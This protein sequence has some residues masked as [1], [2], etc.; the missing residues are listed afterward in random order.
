MT[1]LLA[2][3]GVVVVLALLGAGPVTAQDPPDSLPPVPDSLQVEGLE[4]DSLLAEGEDSIPPVIRNLPDFGRTGVEGDPGVLRNWDLADLQQAPAITLQELLEPVAGMLPVRGGDYA[5]PEHITAVGLGGGRVRVF[6]DGVEELP[7]DGSVTDLSRV[8]LAG[9]G[10]VTL[11]REGGELRIELESERADEDARPLTRIEAGTGDLETNLFRGT[12][13]QPDALGG[14]VGVGIERIDTRG[15]R[16]VEQ[17]TLSGVWLRYLRPVGPVTL[18]AEVRRGIANIDVDEL[19]ATEASRNTWTIRARAGEPGGLRGEVYMAN[20]SLDLDGGQSLTGVPIRP[21]RLQ[22][23]QFGARGA[24]GRTTDALSLWARGGARL[25]QADGGDAPPIVLPDSTGPGTDSFEPAG[26]PDLRLDL[27][28]G[29]RLAG[30]GGASLRLGLD[31]WDGTARGIAGLRAWTEPLF[32]LSAFVELDRG[33]RGWRPTYRRLPTDSVLAD[34]LSANFAQP[35]TRF[36]DRE[37]TRVGARFGL[38]PIDLTGAWLSLTT[39]SVLPL[40]TADRAGLVARDGLAFAGD[41]VTGFEIGG[42]IGIPILEGLALTG[43]LQQ[44][45]SEGIYRPERIYRGGFT[46]NRTFYPTGNLEFNTGVLVE[47]RDGMLLPFPDPDSPGQVAS[48]PFYQSW[49]AHLLIRVVTVRLFVR[50]ENL[51]LRQNNQDL[52]G[53]LLPTTRVV[54]GVRWTLWN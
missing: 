1:R 19:G 45:E 9:V 48:V 23:R 31:D 32:G 49:N 7:L 33:E 18:A 40:G 26:S 16:G 15:S 37:M 42:R 25:F 39:D 50:W 11:R 3:A 8:P 22:R 43:S 5:T 6:V 29:A 46:F 27:D 52:P 4:A 20:T 34:S 17:G 54:Y 2:T 30:V 24:W 51:F 21:G 53:L 36:T 28:L 44:W 41:E 14:A 38:G 10:S 12:F 47:G 35:A 13:I